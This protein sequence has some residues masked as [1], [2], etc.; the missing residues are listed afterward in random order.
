MFSTCNPIGNPNGFADVFLEAGD[1]E[2]LMRVSEFQNSTQAAKSMRLDVKQFEQ[3]CKTSGIPSWPHDD[4]AILHNLSESQVLDQYEKDHIQLHLRLWRHRPLHVEVMPPWVLILKTRERAHTLAKRR[5][6]R[7]ALSCSLTEAA[8]R[9]DTSL[10]V[11]KAFCR[12]LGISKWPHRSL[13]AISLLQNS[14][15]LGF[16][17]AQKVKDHLREWIIDPI[18]HDVLPHWI[19]ELSERSYKTKSRHKLKMS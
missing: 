16:E 13:V 4:L 14:P 17:D 3:F 6:L 15:H 5:L 1:T 18:A 11:F 7:L 9:I 8:K 2:F 10:T 12:K 19:K